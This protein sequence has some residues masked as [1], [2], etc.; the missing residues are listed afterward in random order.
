MFEHMFHT[1]PE[2]CG[3]LYEDCVQEQSDKGAQ[4]S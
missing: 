3:K 1:R 4:H 2:N